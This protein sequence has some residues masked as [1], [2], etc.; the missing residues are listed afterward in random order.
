ME[1]KNYFIEIKKTKK[2]NNELSVISEE[3]MR[4]IILDFNS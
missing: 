4:G 2:R 1:K 3:D